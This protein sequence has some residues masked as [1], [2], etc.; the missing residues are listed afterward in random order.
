MTNQL[1]TVS[2]A[3]AIINRLPLTPQT[4]LTSLPAAAGSVLAQDLHALIDI[5]AFNQSGMDGYAFAFADLD[6][7]NHSLQIVSKIAAGSGERITLQPGQAARVFTGAPLPEGSDTVVMQ[8]NTTINNGQLY[9]TQPTLQKGDN[10]RP[11]GSEIQ[12][13]QLAL[14]KGTVITPGTIG[15]LAGMGYAQVPV[16]APPKIALLVT[17]DELQ[18]PG[19]PLQYGQVYEATSVML[20]AL[21]LQMGITVTTTYVPDSLDATIA[22][23]D[24][25]LQQADIILLTGGVSVGE[26]DFVVR[27]AQS[28]GVQQLF[29]RVLQ[30]PGKPLYAGVK[31]EKTVIGLPGNPSSVLTC[32]YQY[33]W[34]LLRKLTGHNDQLQQLQAPLAGP[35]RKPH[36]L[37]HFL[38][39]QYANG[40]V[41]LLPAQESYRMRSFAVANCLVEL[42]EPA[43]TYEENDLVHLYLL[44]QYG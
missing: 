13:G 30:R 22:A 28:C 6:T 35:H 21:L 12:K 37:R 33:V 5:P 41:T 7:Y 24:S 15:F 16:Y 4:V 20:E 3:K 40:R 1:I 11:A 36:A 31:L 32:F 42:P 34:P 9:I 25:A 23:L 38:K 44:P 2:E 18:S 8:E 17:G 19:T 26:F 43:A 29:H 14:S 10:F 27:A 39:G